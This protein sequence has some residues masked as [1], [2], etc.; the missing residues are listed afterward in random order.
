LH[1]THQLGLKL[2]AVCGAI[3]RSNVVLENDI[4]LEILRGFRVVMEVGFEMVNAAFESIEAL[5]ELQEKVGIDF[6]FFV[7]TGW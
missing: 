4:A 1:Q 6:N 7:H 2:L 5:G 3:L